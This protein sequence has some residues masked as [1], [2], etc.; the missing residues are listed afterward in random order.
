MIRNAKP[1][2]SVGTSGEDIFTRQSNE[3]RR[4]QGNEKKIIADDAR[5]NKLIKD[6]YDGILLLDKDLNVVYRSSS[7]ERISGWNSSD[8][9]NSA[10]LAL[11][12]P[13]DMQMVE[14]VFRDVLVHPGLSITCTFQ[15]KHF[16]GHFIWLECIFTNMLHEPDIY[17]II[18][19]YRDISERKQ[20][21]ELLQQTNRE[22]FAYKY[23]LDE[24]A[25]VTI[26]DQKGVIN[27]VNDN[28]CK[29]SKYSRE[30]LMGQDLR[31]V[32]SGHHG[33]EYIRDMWVTIAKGKIW[34]GEF[35]NK[36]KDGTYYWVDNTIVP[37]LN[38]KGKP[39]KYVSIRTDITERKL[40]EEERNRITA[41]LV[42]RN[43]GLEQYA[44]I[45][46]HNLR[47]PIA[48]I[49]GLSNLLYDFERDG[50]STAV[51]NALSSSVNKLDKVILDLNQMLQLDTQVNDKAELV[52]LS[53][54]VEDVRSDIG[55]MIVKNKVILTCNFDEVS[56]ILILKSYLYSIFRNLIIN[57]IK[58]QRAGTDPVI[59]ISSKMDGNMIAICF[60]DNGEGIDLSKYG[61][62]LFGLY[63]RFNLNVEGKGMGLFMVKMQ[64][65]NLGGRISVQ[66]AVNEGTQ[67]LIELPVKEKME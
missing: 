6:S 42:H 47:A 55:Q 59:S 54:L 3:D 10:M 51:L 52:S 18:C 49:Q 22:L 45:I 17:A 4:E 56:E 9:I 1:G 58:Y 21:D 39:Y 24:A 35:K 15:K 23:A 38:K 36:A 61:S 46:S 67:F 40:A 7:A 14:L 34:K 48:N 19:N 37:F 25:I 26:T 41:D 60:M 11:V 66:S 5:F 30:E 63:K 8:G 16:E 62:Q 28:F 29:I 27:H 20:S 57:S 33:K 53:S 64:V 31:I 50:E 32:N 2:A 43:K 44:Y 65:E 13:A 12:H